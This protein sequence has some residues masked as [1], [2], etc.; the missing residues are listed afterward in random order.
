MSIEYK[1]QRLRGGWAIA[2]YENGKRVSRRQ[3]RSSDAADAAV[4]F[5]EAVAIA[6]KPVDPDVSEIWTA[7]RQ[8]RA[9][10][11]ISENME[12]SGKAILLFFGAKKPASI[13]TEDC[14]EYAKARCAAGRQNGTICTERGHLRC[15]L[16]LAKNSKMIAELPYIERPELPPPKERHLTR[17]EAERVI[18]GASA[19]HVRLFIIL[20][21]ST[22]ARM[23]ALLEL[24]W[25]RVDFARGLIVLGS[26]DRT[27]RQKGRAT[28]P[29]TQTAR[30]ALSSAKE[31]KMS[32]YVIEHGGEKIATIKKGVK[33]A[34]R[35]AKVAGVTPHV[36]R[37]TAAVWMAE[38]GVDMEEI[39]SYLGH[40]DST[41]TKRVYA[42]FS[43][44]H[45]KKAAGSLEMKIPPFS[46][47]YAPASP[48]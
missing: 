21:L 33:E 35:R 38:D 32:D 23:S 34:A 1:L 6:R 22:A 30:A 16:K 41:I 47:R 17:R 25:D 42:K 44:E 37:H 24:T 40:S 8:D 3:L 39:A 7:Y 4:E 45:L 36:F 48:A 15:A 2:G 10:R 43:P 18:L 14:R 13:T 31:G 20:A 27:A 5:A 11:R 9:G 19:P 46:T 28:V 26:L 29:M 12:W